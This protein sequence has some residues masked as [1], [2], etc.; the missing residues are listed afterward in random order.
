M[1]AL[2]RDLPGL[3]DDEMLTCLVRMVVVVISNEIVIEVGDVNSTVITEIV[4][5]DD[6]VIIPDLDKTVEDRGVYEVL[7]IRVIERE[8]WTTDE[9]SCIFLR[10]RNFIVR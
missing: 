5:I 8:H 10:R 3:L 4:S 9:A 1:L 2:K 7:I 6:G